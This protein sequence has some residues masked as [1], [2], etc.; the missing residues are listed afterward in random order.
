[1]VKITAT[2]LSAGLIGIT[3]LLVG[4]LIGV[5]INN[6]NAPGCHNHDALQKLGIGAELG[7]RLGH[8]RFNQLV[9]MC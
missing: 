5:A 6:T 4:I 8:L 7:A 2:A 1:M 3:G 9:N